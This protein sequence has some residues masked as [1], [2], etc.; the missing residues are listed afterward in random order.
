MAEG[1][2][3][4]INPDDLSDNELEYELG[5]RK[6]N[7]KESVQQKRERL[8]NI[9]Q[10]EEKG[11]NTWNIES[12][13]GEELPLVN[14]K[15]KKIEAGL[16]ENVQVKWISQL[17]HWRERINRTETIDLAQ[18][19]QKFE[20]LIRISKLIE[21]YKTQA[22]RLMNLSDREEHGESESTESKVK[23]EENITLLDQSLQFESSFAKGIKES[24]KVRKISPIK[25]ADETSEDHSK[26]Q[27]V[28]SK[29][30]DQEK[31]DRKEIRGHTEN[32]KVAE[33]SG[34]AGSDENKRNVKSEKED[35]K[36]NKQEK[37]HKKKKLPESSSSD[38]ESSSL[39][40]LSS[41]L[42]TSSS[43]TSSLDSL[44]DKDEKSYRRDHKFRHFRL[45]KWGIQFSGDPQGME[46]PTSSSK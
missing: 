14:R 19:D 2:I 21:T 5:I 44:P 23:A 18:E 32:S 35:K 34:A 42:S 6:Q 40:S 41:L 30:H 45:D 1:E 39:D 13:M 8:R 28:K 38:S 20:T 22:R 25:T 3:W 33:K 31:V 27:K 16:K 4:M 11:S 26:D 12:N 37:K 36:R 15:L 29:K 24:M 46:F 17:R 9:F 10:S 7:I 43:S